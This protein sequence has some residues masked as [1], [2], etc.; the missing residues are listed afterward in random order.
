[1]KS[2]KNFKES[3]NSCSRC[4]LCQAVCPIYQ[5]T[6]NDCTS[7]RG[8]FILIND[9]LKNNLKPSKKLKNYM[10]M[11]INCKKCINYCPSKIDT[12]KINEAFFKDFFYFKIDL[13]GI[14]FLIRYLLN[15]LC[16]IFQKNVILSTDK[17]VIYLT[18]FGE[19]EIP[20]IIKKFD[21]KVIEC[22]IPIK[23]ALSNPGLY[24]KLAK[25]S[26][27]KIIENN[28]DII[29]TKNPLCKTELQIGLQKTKLKIH[30][31]N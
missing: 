27:K 13:L 9:L 14:P 26:A 4:G 24:K 8:K 11:C 15:F 22:G 21:Y 19:T 2:L 20:E 30:Y 23:F 16:K 18:E 7:P 5:I 25:I 12:I 29:L 31:I 3:I 10:T 28:I 17:K 6:K 1:M